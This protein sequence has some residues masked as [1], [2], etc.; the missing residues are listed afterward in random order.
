MLPLGKPLFVFPASFEWKRRFGRSVRIDVDERGI[1]TERGGKQVRLR[2]IDTVRAEA[3]RGQITRLTD[4][5]GTYVAIPKGLP[6]ARLLLDIVQ[7]RLTDAH[8]FRMRRLGPPRG[9]ATFTQRRRLALSFLSGSAVATAIV[10]WFSLIYYFELLVSF[11]S[12]A[13]YFATLP[14]TIV[15]GHNHIDIQSRIRSTLVDPAQIKVVELW[16]IE[17]RGAVIALRLSNFELVELRDFGAGTLALFD[18]LKQLTERTGPLAASA[19]VRR[20]FAGRRAGSYAAASLAAIAALLWMPI[21]SGRALTDG[22]RILPLSAIELLLDAGSLVDRTDRA[23]RT[24]TYNAAK[25]GRL[26]VLELLLSR[27][28]DPSRRASNAPG[29]TPLHVAAEYNQVAAVKRLLAA[30]VSPNVRN[31]WEDTPLMQLASMGHRTETELQ[32][33]DILVAAGA[34]VTLADKDGFTALHNANEAGQEALAQALIRHGADPNAPNR[35]NQSPW[36]RAMMDRVPSIAR[37]L[38]AAG[39]D[40]NR[41]MPDSDYNWLRQFVA[42]NNVEWSTLLLECGA[43]T[44]IAGSDGFMPLQIAVRHNHVQLTRLL[45]DA[46]ADVNGSTDRV[47]PPLRLAVN[48]K[49]KEIIRLLLDRRANTNAIY[50]DVSAL[51]LAANQADAELVRWLIDAGANVHF[52]SPVSAPPLF[53]AAQAGSAD[54]VEALLDAGADPNVRYQGFSPLDA[55]TRFQNA[56]AKELLIAAGAR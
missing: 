35:H 16:F 3:A 6:N 31:N 55:A 33:V 22:A 42:T 4:G 5:A 54:A 19:P 29:F 7:E 18:R 40:V 37:A 11:I 14:A 46:K 27:G 15:V 9:D 50:G 51:Q 43:R 8:G 20:E 36:D 24:A 41:P 1:A 30:G 38:C 28:A 34:D 13:I 12:S 44:D 47:G 53:I 49:N 10:A 45:L 48:E 32:V 39:A 17:D 56:R 23:G 25:F 2:W 21:A 52:M 26:D